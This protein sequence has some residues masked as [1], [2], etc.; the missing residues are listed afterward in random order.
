[1][2]KMIESLL[3]LHQIDQKIRDTDRLIERLPAELA[4]GEAELAALEGR[5][6]EILS[7]ARARQVEAD[8]ANVEIKDLEGRIDKYQ[9]QLNIAKT[10]KEF[11]VLKSEIATAQAGISELE[12]AALTAYEEADGL[13]VQARGL[14]P[15]IAAVQQRLKEQ[16][17]ALDGRLNELRKDRQEL[18]ACRSGATA[19]VEA[20]ALKI[21]SQ[22]LA[23]YTDGAM[24]R[25][26]LGICTYCNMK[27]SPQS[28]NL[29]LMGD[30]PQ[31]C[32]SCGR[33]CF[34][35][36]AVQSAQGAG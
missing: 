13:G 29:V 21:Y 25:V 11:D 34:S 33:I 32:R 19:G 3:A 12:T 31:Q 8:R 7:Q 10:Q 15:E 26:E 6:A 24:A 35:G 4:D 28:W 18:A 36:E 17:A 27:L 20:E 14:D 1:M 9:L 2:S 30:R 22:V 23:K 16:R 5:K